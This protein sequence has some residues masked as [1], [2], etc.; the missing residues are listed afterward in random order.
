[1]NERDKLIKLFL[2]YKDLL[3]EKQQSYFKS[4]YFEDLSFSEIAENNKVSKALVGKTIN[5]I[6]SKLNEYE[7]ILKIS[8]LYTKIELILDDIKNDKIKKEFEDLIK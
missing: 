3:T 1:M 8:T 5:N 4:Y 6:A 2:I 7:S